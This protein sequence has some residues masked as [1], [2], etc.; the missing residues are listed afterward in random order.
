MKTRRDVEWKRCSDI[1]WCPDLN[2][3]YS[4]GAPSYGDKHIKNSA[5]TTTTTTND[6]NNNTDTTTTTNN[7]NTHDNNNITI[8]IIM[9]IMIL[10]IPYDLPEEKRCGRG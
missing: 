4:W 2:M 6:D 1:L 3:F 7:N 8:M 9:I 10:N 5:T